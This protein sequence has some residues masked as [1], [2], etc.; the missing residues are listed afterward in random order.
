[1]DKRERLLQLL[2]R[3]SRI[4]V[5]ALCKELSMSRSSTYTLIKSLKDDGTIRRFTI[6]RGDTLNATVGIKA[7]LLLKFDVQKA[8]KVF[9]TVLQTPCMYKLELMFGPFDAMVTYHIDN[10]SF[11]DAIRVEL[12]NTEEIYEVQTLI[13][14]REVDH[15]NIDAI[16]NKSLER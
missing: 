4:S 1:M 10:A 6:E 11:L 7:Y 14:Q 12:H 2:E 8:H 5:N 13:F 16:H 9:R 15:D 3:D